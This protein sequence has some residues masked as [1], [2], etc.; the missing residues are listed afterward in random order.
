[1][2]T[3][4]PVKE[5]ATF[6]GWELDGTTFVAGQTKITTTTTLKAVYDDNPSL[7]VTYI[8]PL[9]Y[10]G[11]LE[12]KTTHEYKLGDDISAFIND[13]KNTSLLS[14]GEHFVGVYQA[15][16]QTEESDLS[17][18]NFVPVTSYLMP[19]DRSR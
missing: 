12:G 1:M 5:N 6:V 2:D 10:E 7:S 4:V 9:G 18:M 16:N 15:T 14:E 11:S 8:Y 19:K 13:M 17:Q 3:Y